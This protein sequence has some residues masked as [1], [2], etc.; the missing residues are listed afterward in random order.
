MPERPHIPEAQ[1]RAKVAAD[2]AGDRWS[3]PFLDNK[4]PPLLQSA[5]EQ[6]LAPIKTKLRKMRTKARHADQLAKLNAVMRRQIKLLKETRGISSQG[7]QHLPTDV[8]RTQ[9]ATLAAMG[10]TKKGIARFMGVHVATINEHYSDELDIGPLQANLDVAMTLHSVATDRKH[11]GVIPAAKKWLESRG[12]GQWDAKQK[13][14][15]T[16]AGA[17]ER[18]VIDVRSLDPEER[19]QF[20]ALLEK[21]AQAQLTDERVI[22][23]QG[24]LPQGVGPADDS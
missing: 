4:I 8:T 3:M 16:K 11:A 6:A 1:Y 2:R 18:S 13:I 23:E 24:L 21:M 17:G 9:V 5:E 14:E 19:E 20:K 12:D 7:I 22:A 15:H 10:M